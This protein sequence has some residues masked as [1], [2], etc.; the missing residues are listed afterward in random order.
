[1][2]VQ[3][4]IFTLSDKFVVPIAMSAVTERPV[5]KTQRVEVCIS[6]LSA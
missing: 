6:A 3:L 2:L 4:N 1:M 5:E